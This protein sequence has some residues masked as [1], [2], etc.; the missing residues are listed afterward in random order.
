MNDVNTLI[1]IAA[2]RQYHQKN[3]GT[4]QA[5]LDKINLDLESDEFKENFELF[6]EMLTDKLALITD[7]R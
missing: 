7:N 3:Y 1:W 2:W 5:L 4:A 6:Q